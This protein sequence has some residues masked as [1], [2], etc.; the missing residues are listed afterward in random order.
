M[1]S[2][3]RR[4]TGQTMTEYIFILAIAVAL[5]IV[6]WTKVKP[7]AEAKATDIGTEINNIKMK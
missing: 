2:I 4:R 1:K 3:I 6:I 7:K 5:G